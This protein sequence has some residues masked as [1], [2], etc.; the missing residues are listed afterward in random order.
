[1]VNNHHVLRWLLTNKAVW[2]KYVLSRKILIIYE[3]YC[4]HWYSHCQNIQIYLTPRMPYFEPPH[5]KLHFR[6]VLIWM[7]QNQFGINSAIYRVN[8]G[9]VLVKDMQT[10]PPQWYAMFW[11]EWK[12]NFSFFFNPWFC[13]QFPSVFTDQIWR[14]KK[15]LKRCAMFWN[16]FF[17]SWIFFVRFLV[18]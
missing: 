16:G 15:C 10:S 4:C 13:S 1:M 5:S 11:N 18:F 6:K 12:I 9:L 2:H 14:R 7:Y 17:S 8:I 3:K